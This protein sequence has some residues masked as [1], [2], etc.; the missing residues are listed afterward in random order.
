MAHDT[1]RIIDTISDATSKLGDRLDK[2]DGRWTKGGDH[3]KEVKAVNEF[4]EILLNNFAYT[5][6]E[7]HESANFTHVE[8]LII[9]KDRF[10]NWL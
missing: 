3:T 9:I 4:I 8:A 5:F 10:H 6:S 1:R 7:D 2:R